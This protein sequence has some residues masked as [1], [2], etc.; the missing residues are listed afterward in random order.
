MTTIPATLVFKIFFALKGCVMQMHLSRAIIVEMKLDAYTNPY[1]IL[2][3]S[4]AM[5]SCRGPY[6]VKRPTMRENKCSAP[7]TLMS[8]HTTKSAQAKQKSRKLILCCRPCFQNAIPFSTLAMTPKKAIRGAKTLQRTLNPRIPVS[9]VM[10][11]SGL[12]QGRYSKSLK[13]TRH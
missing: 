3:R 5:I 1:K 12:S 6:N 11:L 13:T 8:R 9:K 2:M 4:L 7:P 10:M